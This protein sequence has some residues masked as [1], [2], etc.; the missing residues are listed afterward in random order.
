MARRTAA[1][2]ASKKVVYA[3]LAG[4]LAIAATKFVAAAITGSAAMLSEGVHSVVDSGNEL[5]LLY[6]LR[7]ANAPPD[8]SHPLGYGREL[9]FWGFVVA[10][11]VFALGAG[12]SI[13]RGIARLISPEPLQQPAVAYTVL[14]LSFVFE[15]ASWRIAY[16]E[17]FAT[18]AGLGFFEAV[19]V[20]KDPSK[21]AVLLE[22]TAA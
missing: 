16:R 7:R 17:F 12:V 13:V 19:R 8:R 15:A 1:Y 2:A 20:S 5:L 22:D 11:L 6:G 10:L 14:A 18:K 21:F 3:A 9:Y 4:N